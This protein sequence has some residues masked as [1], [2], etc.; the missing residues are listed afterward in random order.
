MNKKKI[1]K[2]L[3]LVS[4]GVPAYNA[5]PYLEKLLDSLLGQ[6]YT[7]LEIIIS[8]NCSK[9][10]TKT[11]CKKYVKRDSRIKY[12]E[13]TKFYSAINNQM[14]V[15]DN[16]KGDYFMMAGADDFYDKKWIFSLLQ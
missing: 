9:D 11:I 3:P 16:S 1:K 6:T 13:R 12:I 14:K 2:N 4:I 5:G 15:F 8:N 7:N 10:N